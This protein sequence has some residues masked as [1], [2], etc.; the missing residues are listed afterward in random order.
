[1][2]NSITKTL[3][4]VSFSL[5]ISILYTTM[6]MNRLPLELIKLLKVLLEW[7]HLEIEDQMNPL[8]QLFNK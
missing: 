3:F 7:S 4:L 8:S 5:D 1:L 6:K 2:I